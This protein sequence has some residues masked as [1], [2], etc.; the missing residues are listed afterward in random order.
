MQN[1][2]RKDDAICS[3]SAGL[4]P[5]EFDQLETNPVAIVIR[6]QR[7]YYRWCNLFN[8]CTAALNYEETYR[9]PNLLGPG[10]GWLFFQF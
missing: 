2:L 7:G 10:S 4:S 8:M 6:S 5:V 9:Y 1:V 3:R